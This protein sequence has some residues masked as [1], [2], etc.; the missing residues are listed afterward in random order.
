MP[1]RPVHNFIMLS[2][3]RLLTIEA[4]LFMA[5]DGNEGMQADGPSLPK[6]FPESDLSVTP[7]LRVSEFV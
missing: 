7:I 1:C 3:S 5:G 2:G 6:E 4:S